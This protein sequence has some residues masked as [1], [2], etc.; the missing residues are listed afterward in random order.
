M[1]S[2]HCVLIF[3]ERGVARKIAPIKIQRFITLITDYSRLLPCH[4]GLVVILVVYLVYLVRLH[5]DF[6]L[7][8]LLK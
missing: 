7:S 3:S 5:K 8:S 1:I 4:T 2:F 6:I